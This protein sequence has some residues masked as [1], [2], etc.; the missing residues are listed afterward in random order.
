MKVQESVY[1]K[2]DI[3]RERQARVHLVSFFDIV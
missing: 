1:G 2:S 3:E